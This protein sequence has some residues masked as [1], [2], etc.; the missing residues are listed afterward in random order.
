MK[1]ETRFGYVRC[2]AG[3]SNVVRWRKLKI[4]K[5]WHG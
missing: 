1:N 3:L 4:S 2:P 5:W